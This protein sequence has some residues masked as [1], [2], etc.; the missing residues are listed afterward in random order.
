L[1]GL[2]YRIERS[3]TP[4]ADRQPYLARARRQGL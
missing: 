2:F 4:W 3:A 1:S